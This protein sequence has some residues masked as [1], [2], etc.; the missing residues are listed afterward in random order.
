MIISLSALILWMLS[1]PTNIYAQT[2]NDIKVLERKNNS[3]FQYFHGNFIPIQDNMHIP[4]D[5]IITTA[6]DGT[7]EL[8]LSS[9][10]KVF[11]YKNTQFLIKNNR[12]ELYYG[13][14][15]L[16]NTAKLFVNVFDLKFEAKNASLLLFVQNQKL[17]LMVQEGN[18]Y[19]MVMN[20]KNMCDVK[21][22]YLL[23][24]GKI[25][26]IEDEDENKTLIKKITKNY[27]GIKNKV[28]NSSQSNPKDFGFLAEKNYAWEILLKEQNKHTKMRLAHMNK[29]REKEI[30]D[31]QKK[32][33]KNG[34][35]KT[36]KIKKCIEFKLEN[37]RGSIIESCSKYDEVISD[38]SCKF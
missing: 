35:A 9:L 33:K 30:V 14:I 27:W 31:E 32:V 23:Q 22:I 34:K 36:C 3:Y 11:V 8:E 21:K 29:L 2:P 24:A 10:G 38:L 26:K 19:Q 5:S 13:R 1:L 12:V 20:K 17:S 7:L 16:I 4:N 25:D 15:H 18:V 37:Y 28:F 6:R